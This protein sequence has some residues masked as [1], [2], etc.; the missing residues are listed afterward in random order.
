M[1]NIFI[2][3]FPKNL[4]RLT[5]K[6]KTSLNRLLYCFR[7]NKVTGFTKI[8]KFSYQ[9]GKKTVFLKI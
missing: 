2:K 4:N 8:T 3:F 9:S 7:R 5:I 1:H 6:L